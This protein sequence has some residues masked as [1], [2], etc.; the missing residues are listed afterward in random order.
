MQNYYNNQSAV[1][2]AIDWNKYQSKVSVQA[3]NQYLDQLSNPSFQGVNRRFASSFEN[4]TN[5]TKH[6]KYYYFPKVEKNSIIP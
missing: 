1:K 2:L 4:I 3:Q 5:R 6:T